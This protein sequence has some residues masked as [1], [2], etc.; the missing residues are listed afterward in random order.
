MSPE[1]LRGDV[2]Q[3]LGCE[4]CQSA[5]PL[6]PP[7]LSEAHIFALED[8]LSGKATAAVRD[9]AGS[10]YVR[11]GRLASQAALYA[12]ATNQRQLLPQL[13]ALS[14]N[15]AEPVRTHARWAYEKLGGETP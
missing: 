13:L 2:Y 7:G 6:N 4:K 14:Q 11:P 9:L 10:N 15:A 8:L 5:C 1:A 12:A 3:I